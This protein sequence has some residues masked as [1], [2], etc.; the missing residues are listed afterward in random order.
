MKF[1]L[2]VHGFQSAELTQ[3]EAVLNVVE[4]VTTAEATNFD[5]IWMGHHFASDEHQK[6]QPVPMLSRLAAESDDMHFGMNLLIPLHHPLV[7]AEQCATM[8]AITNG[9]FILSP[10][11]GYRDIEFE[12]LSIPKD[13]RG[14]RLEE[15][16][17]AIKRLWMEED[18]TFNG[19]HFTFEGV[20]IK[21][22]PIQKPRPPIWIGANKDYGVKRSVEI[23]D[24]WLINP[25]EAND[26]ISRQLDLI[27][28]AKSESDVSDFHNCQPAFKNA[29]VAETDERAFEVFGPH[30]E[31]L[32]D[33]YKDA[34]QHKATET[35]EDFDLQFEELQDQRALVGSVETVT[36]Q[37]VRLYEE[38]GIDCLIFSMHFP[39]VDQDILCESIRLAGEEVI[40]QVRRRIK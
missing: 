16:V 34:G 36:E 3:A 14:S 40:P 19:N 17:E 32:F 21:P 12:T 1:G 35:P 23:G 27:D 5:L 37:A 30:M 39:G 38:L 15:G 8:D 2:H 7:I 25:H 26:T 29:F 13:E 20:S 28:D 9:K 33:W 18:V 31:D 4:Q 22:K 6:F 24:A 10:I 11:A